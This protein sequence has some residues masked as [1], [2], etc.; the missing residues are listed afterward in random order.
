MVAKILFCVIAASVSLISSD[1]R[2]TPIDISVGA[3]ASLLPNDPSATVLT[4]DDLPVGSL[5]SY[6]F[7]GGTLMGDGAV[8]DASLP[9]KFAP[10]A[11]DP[12]KYLTVSYPAAAGIV[13]FAFSSQGNYFGLYWGSMDSY[14]SITFLEDHEQIATFS[15]AAVAGLTG[16]V[17][18]G[19]QQSSL[20]NRYINFYL[21]DN[22]YNAVLLSTTDFGFEVD[23]IAFGDSPLPMPEPGTLILLGSPLYFILLRRIRRP[24]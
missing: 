20:S 9:G 3:P 17:A 19:D 22:F 14:N 24:A 10:P 7:A 16:L 5:P 11:G 1:G 4:F 2:A 8:E 18:N 21:G 23:N 12:T 6:E 15:G 13:D